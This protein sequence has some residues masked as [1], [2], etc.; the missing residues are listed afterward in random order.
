MTRHTYTHWEDVYGLAVASVMIAVGAYLLHVAR[1]TTGGTVGLSLVFSQITPVPFGMISIA[2]NLPLFLF[3]WRMMG[4]A[5]I[6][7]SLAV[8]VMTAALVAYMPHW[9]TAVE[10]KPMFGALAGGTIVGMGALAAARHGGAAGGTFVVV[11]WLQRRFGV[12]AGFAQ[13]SLDLVVMLLAALLLGW[14]VALW[15]VLGV[16][17]TDA[18]IMTWYRPSRGAASVEVAGAP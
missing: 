1:I 3:G 6:I 9:I 2:L 16:I 13:L 12:N 10:I 8:T 14:I 11:L 7:K 5:F 4:S 18:M 15:S 17:A